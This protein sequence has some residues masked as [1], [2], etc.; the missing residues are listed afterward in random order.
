MCD[1]QKFSDIISGLSPSEA[2]CRLDEMLRDDPDNAVLLFLRGKERWR[3]GRHRDA[4]NDYERAVAADASSPAVHA[5]EMARDVMNFFNP[6]L[7]N[8]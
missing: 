3:I 8:P 2:I 5:L 4:I 7:L 1:L 6:D